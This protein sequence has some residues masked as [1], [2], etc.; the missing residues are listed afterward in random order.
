VLA[1]EFMGL[2]ASSSM[3]R[4]F[5]EQGD[6]MGA[7]GI[8]G[9][10]YTLSGPVVQGFHVG[11][12]LGF[13]T[14]NLQV[15]SEKLIPRRGV[16][17]VWVV[18]ADGIRHAGMLNIGQRPTVDNGSELSIEVHVIGYEGNLYGQNITLEFIKRLRPERRF[19]TL[20]QLKVQL[21]QDKILAIDCLKSVSCQ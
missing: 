3:C 8:L 4:K 11:H 16:Y 19:D 1:K 9:Y 10:N 13:P 18:L 12:E 2:H 14:A 6:V 7:A 20:E 15:P 21:E 17:A 5:L